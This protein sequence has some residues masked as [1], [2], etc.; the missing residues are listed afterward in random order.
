MREKRYKLTMQPHEP[1]ALRPVMI[2]LPELLQINQTDPMRS[3]IRRY[4]HRNA[5]LICNHKNATT[6]L[7]K[8]K[9]YK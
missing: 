6:H 2:P 9:K 1:K 8:K 3:K 7:I 5:D 4:N